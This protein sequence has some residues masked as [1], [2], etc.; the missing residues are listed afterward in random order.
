LYTPRTHTE[1]EEVQIHPFLTLAL[2]GSEWSA[3][4]PKL[5]HHPQGKASMFQLNRRLG[6]PQSW[7]VGFGEEQFLLTCPDSTPRWSHP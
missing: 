3:P 4:R 1:E 2:D 6:G 5:T 7:P